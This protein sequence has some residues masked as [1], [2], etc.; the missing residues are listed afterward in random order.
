MGFQLRSRCYVC[1]VVSCNY[2][3]TAED[4]NTLGDFT[5]HRGTYPPGLGLRRAWSATAQPSSIFV[6]RR[7]PYPTDGKNTIRNKQGQSEGKK[8]VV[9]SSSK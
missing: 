5:F 6:I 2:T 3:L 9:Q 4:L 7:R 8:I 1:G